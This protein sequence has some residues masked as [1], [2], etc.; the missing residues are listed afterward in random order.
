MVLCLLSALLVLLFSWLPKGGLY[1]FVSQ[2][3]WGP[4][5]LWLA[6]ASLE[7]KGVDR[8]DPRKDYI[9]FANHSSY[10]DIPALCA[11]IPQPLFFIA[12][13]EILKVP[14]FGWGMWAIGM[15]FVDRSNPEKAKASMNKAAKAIQKGK[16]VLAFPEGTRS[17]SG[18]LQ[19]FKKGIFHV[20]KQGP[21]AMVPVAIRG[22]REVLSHD[23][24]LNRGHICI[25]I[26]AA[27]DED[28]IAEKSVNELA[29]YTHKSLESM[30]LK[31]SPKTDAEIPLQNSG[32]S[33]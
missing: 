6:G 9:F 3:M 8:I 30:L 10:Y 19:R 24:K 12:K 14:I 21:I 4:G 11:A 7:V 13:R 5:L 17:R 27:I 29:A 32:Q 33:A 2:K 23:G 20:A 25:E 18:Q 26:G 16:S 31:D 28:L 1:P 22:S 15:V